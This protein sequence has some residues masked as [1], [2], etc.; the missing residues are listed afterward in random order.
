[1]KIAARRLTVILIAAAALFGISIYAAYF[2]AR[3]ADENR[4]RVLHTYRAIQAARVLLSLAQDAE[5]GQRGYL[6][7]RTD[8]YLQPYRD[9]VAAIPGQ[10]AEVEALVTD[11]QDQRARVARLRTLLRERLDILE[12]GIAI[13][14]TGGSTSPGTFL[15]SNPD[16]AVM[17]SVRAAIDE[18]LNEE[19]RLLAQREERVESSEAETLIVSL[20]GAVLGL[21][22][23]IVASVSL[24]RNYRRLRQ[25]EIALMHKTVELQGTLDN[26]RDGIAVFGE[27]RLLTASNDRFFRLFDLP[28]EFRRDR[29]AIDE[30]RTG[31]GRPLEALLRPPPG[32]A[33][34]IGEGGGTLF[35]IDHNG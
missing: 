18:I 2:L 10:L 34:Q 25:G 26:C 13:V 20:I 30:L 15:L 17:D 16:K 24:A 35:Q 8:S 28:R 21:V 31:D 11:S 19:R 12:Q 32:A 33:V 6:L 3:S 22:A 7:T 23:L 27:D 5:T 1:M 4:A 9:A 14:R 29:R